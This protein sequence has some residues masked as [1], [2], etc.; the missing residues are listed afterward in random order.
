MQDK[1]T[2]LHELIDS[3]VARHSAHLKADCIQSVQASS[4]TQEALVSVSE[5]VHPI[6]PVC[7][8]EGAGLT[9]LSHALVS[10][11]KLLAARR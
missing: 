3:A 5:S 6:V 1:R 4:S 2:C 7:M 8:L 10:V 11:S 9:L